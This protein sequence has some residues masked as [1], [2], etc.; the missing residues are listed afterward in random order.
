M[1]KAIKRRTSNQA[2]FKK[3]KSKR[4]I[5]L[6]EMMVVIFLIGI[7]TA[8]IAYNYQ[9]TLEKGRAFKTEQG[10]N[11]VET[12]LNLRVAEDPDLLQNL[13]RDWPE[14]IRSDPLVKDP[15]ALINDGWGQPLKLEI[16]RDTNAIQ[17]HSEKLNLYK[18]K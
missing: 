10:I 17:M 14:I 2:L 16:N 18:R 8:V 4:M 5:T 7:I 13:D 11:R 6:M 9:G 1:K 12:I 3:V 15:K